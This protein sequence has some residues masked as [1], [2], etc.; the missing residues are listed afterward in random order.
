MTKTTNGHSIP[1]RPLRILYWNCDGI[2]RDKLLFDYILQQQQIDIA[3]LC[4]TKLKQNTNWKIRNYYIYNTPGPNPTHGGTAVIVKACIPHYQLQLPQ[5]SN[6]QLTAIKIPTRHEELCIGALYHSPSFKIIEKD[7]DEMQQISQSF[8]LAGD[9]NSKNTDWNSR[10]TTSRG[11]Q[12]ARHAEN[13]NYEIFGPTEPTYYPYSPSYKPDVLDIVLKRSS[14]HILNMHTIAELNSDH[15]PVIMEVDT[16]IQHN[17]FQVKCITR[18]NWALFRLLLKETIPHETENNIETEQELDEVINTFTNTIIQQKKVAT[19][20]IVPNNSSQYKIPNL[21]SL[22]QQKR[23]LRRRYRCTRQSK[24]KTEL[25]NITRQ[26]HKIIV[27]HRLDKLDFDIEEAINKN[28]IWPITKRFKPK[29]RIRSTA[30][31]GRYGI[32]YSSLEKAEAISEV[33]QGQFQPHPSSTDQEIISF[34]GEI[35]TTVR[36]FLRAPTTSDKEF[37]TASEVKKFVKR[38]K[39]NK[40]P[41]PDGI[42]NEMLKNLPHIAIKFLSHIINIGLRLNYFP[43]PWKHANIITIPKQGKNPLHPKNL[44]PISLLSNLGKIYEKIILSRMMEKALEITPDSQFAF[45]PHRSTTLQ[46]L[47]LAEYIQTGFNHQEHTTA[48]FLDVEKA[49]D[50]VWYDGLIFK[51]IDYKFTDYII[52]IISS[53]LHQRTYQV[54]VDNTLSAIKEM[55]AGVP[56]GSVLAPTLYNLY[57][58]DLP[59]HNQCQIAQYADDTVLYYKHFSI[60]NSTNN[61]SHHLRHM[62]Q[63]C[64]KWRIKVNEEKS[65]V[66][67]FT[68]RRPNITAPLK[69]NNKEIQL[70]IHL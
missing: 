62:T 11:R 4:E 30:I 6:L 61:I 59:S 50:S 29:N 69:L 52:H 21:E 33:F 17:M 37:A 10:I 57:T 23:L 41:G 40:A 2:E 45:M 47:R 65:N 60:I 27:K 43:T 55:S 28:N 7:L 53:F 38:S 25:N 44:R 20:V 42:T 15:E 1:I 56:Q 24:L 36:N 67:I 5:F 22:L 26:I 54:K 3:L 19:T 34:H 18:T 35:N 13:N 8:L 46:L 64:N 14:A 39:S 9:L 51:L 16:N 68:Q 70:L 31:Q 12:L 66:V 63:W 32:V 58:S 49:Y 48:V